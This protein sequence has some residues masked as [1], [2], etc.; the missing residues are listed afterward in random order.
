[1]AEA[2]ARNWTAILLG[3]ASLMFLIPVQHPLIQL[4][5]LRGNA[6]LVPFLIVGSRLTDREG[7]DL[8]ICLA[9]L[10]LMA[11]AFGVAEFLW[12][13]PAFYP[14]N[15]VTEI[16]YRSKDIAGFTAFRIPACFSYAHSYAGTMVTTLPWLAGVWIQPR[17]SGWRRLLLAA[18]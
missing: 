2:G 9:A 11:L 8:A 1:I 3:W 17:Q 5:G 13:V 12:G 7:R 18:G 16:I 14:E 6:F 15:Q 4:V 10:N